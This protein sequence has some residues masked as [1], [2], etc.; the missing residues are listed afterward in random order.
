MVYVKT[1][2]KWKIT[3]LTTFLKRGKR[4]NDQSQKYNVNLEKIKHTLEHPLTC[5]LFQAKRYR[6]LKLN[7]KP[8]TFND[9]TSFKNSTFIYFYL[10][11]GVGAL[12]AIGAVTF[13]CWSVVLGAAGT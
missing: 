12:D 9:L 5:Q 6:T 7:S 10:V 8:L 11:E 13:P 3:K 1:I 2:Q 4:E